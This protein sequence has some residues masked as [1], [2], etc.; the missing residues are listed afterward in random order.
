MFLLLTPRELLRA[1]QSKVLTGHETELAD[2]AKQVVP[3]RFLDCVL[4]P[5][6]MLC[7]SFA[8]YLD[9]R[10]KGLEAKEEESQERGRRE[11]RRRRKKERWIIKTRTHHRRVVGKMIE[12][13]VSTRLSLT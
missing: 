7:E 13:A 2:W 8:K 10:G 11:G 12:R 9:E 1:L 6:D 4:P 5:K 3:F